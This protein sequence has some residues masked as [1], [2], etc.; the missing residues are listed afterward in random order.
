MGI[1]WDE[2]QTLLTM[3]L[4]ALESFGDNYPKDF[5]EKAKNVFV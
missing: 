4:L 5:I 1:D 2:P 3:Q